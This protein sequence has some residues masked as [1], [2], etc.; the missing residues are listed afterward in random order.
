V[1]ALIS[2]LLLF[3]LVTS[4]RADEDDDEPATDEP[5][6]DEPEDTGYIGKRRVRLEIDECPPAPDM[7]QA[8]VERI[9]AE[10]Y[11][12]GGVLYLQ[13]DYEGA[14]HE[15]VQTACALPSAATVLFSIGQSYE[16]LLRYDVAIA[17]YERY[18]LQNRGTTQKD[19]DERRNVSSRIE[20]LQALPAR[21]KVV[22]SPEGAVVSFTDD[23]GVRRN[24]GKI[25]AEPYEVIAGRY[26]MTIELAGYEIV[27]Q[28][29]DP[30]IGQPYSYYFP[31]NPKRG[32]LVI[33][34]EPVDAR[35]F[36][37]D[38]LA[39][40]GH[41]DEFLASG[42][43]KV[44]IEAPG[45]ISETR[46]VEV[47]ADRDV[48]LPVRLPAKPAGGKKQLIVG[49]SVAGGIMGSIALGVLEGGD[50]TARGGLGF[51]GGV[52]LGFVGG[53]YGIPDDIDVGTSSYIITS[54]LIGAAEAGLVSSIIEQDG[55]ETTG[56]VA[57]GGMAAGAIFAAVTAERFN[58]DAGDAAMLNSGAL[59]GAIAGGLFSAIFEFKEGVSEGLVLGGLNLGVISG[60][61]IGGRVDYSRR[62]VALIDLAGLAGMALGVSTQAV[63]DNA[64]K[65]DNDPN[66]DET[67]NERT[68]HFALGGMVVGLAAG[69]WLTRNVDVPKV[70]GLTPMIQ[71]GKDPQGGRTL[72]VSFG[73]SF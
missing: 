47:V 34:A 12:R 18:V 40:I 2:A 37:D 49:S 9:A 13:G 60:V 30:E 26:T 32:H 23:L 5:A 54:G 16:C 42:A 24:M 53:Y 48:E 44:T 56:P 43:Y 7:K 59:W 41:Y 66:S 55:A 21:I 29:I 69:A 6:T 3:S 4:A 46:R 58:F 1:R 36:V 25:G 19:I 8:D 68:A 61:L 65:N 64:T 63:I 33:N 71:G 52:G 35:I 22:T 67:S 39:G 28:V 38:R 20:V 70:K 72:V 62:H 14:I 57:V 27:E 15:F 73:G 45:R 51:L 17:Y 10:H 31:L 11:D 50:N